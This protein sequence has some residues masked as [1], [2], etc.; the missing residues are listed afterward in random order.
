M[1]LGHTRESMQ[2]L[3]IPHTNGA[4]TWTVYQFTPINFVLL[5]PE[6]VL[7]LLWMTY[8]LDK[9]MILYMV[10]YLK[11][12][13]KSQPISPTLTDFTVIVDDKWLISSLQTHHIGRIVY[14][15]RHLKLF[16]RTAWSFLYVMN[17]LQRYF[18]LFDFRRQSDERQS[19]P[20]TSKPFE[21]SQ[22]NG[23]W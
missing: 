14:Y 8:R 10:P 18:L 5:I 20:F 6:V 16:P 15:G 23:F 13:V 9:H 19:L 4:A 3:W 17:T 7:R 11:V 1:T 2:S 22:Y 21:L 12:S